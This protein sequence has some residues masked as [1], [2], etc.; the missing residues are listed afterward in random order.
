MRWMQTGTIKGGAERGRARTTPQPLPPPPPTLVAD[1]T[2]RRA[3]PPR[4]ERGTWSP[5]ATPPRQS[6]SRCLRWPKYS[7][8][9][10][11]RGRCYWHTSPQLRQR[12]T[13]G[14]RPLNSRWARARGGRTWRPSFTPSTSSTSRTT[15]STVCARPPPRSTQ[16][17]RREG[18]DRTAEVRA[19][20]F[21]FSNKHLVV[22]HTCVCCSFVGCRVS[23][24]LHWRNNEKNQFNRLSHHPSW[25]SIRPSVVRHTAGHAVHISIIHTWHVLRPPPTEQWSHLVCRPGNGTDSF[26]CTCTPATLWRV[27]SPGTGEQNTVLTK[28][29]TRQKTRAQNAVHTVSL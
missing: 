19:G 25:Q 23:I 28:V 18:G 15:G 24:L 5:P 4:T 27:P 16:L 29:A 13:A 6:R 11:R 1:G 21:T 3:A 17:S 22:M 7:T 26:T 2:G 9:A 8:S 10:P 12:T 14:A 20:I